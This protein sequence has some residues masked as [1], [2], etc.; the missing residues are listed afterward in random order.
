MKEG[1]EAIEAKLDWFFVYL[2]WGFIVFG[3]VAIGGLVW[4]LHAPD[5]LPAGDYLGAVGAGAGLLSI[6]HGILRHGMSSP[7]REHRDR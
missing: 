2:P 1:L 4:T 5:T 7:K 3:A 6:G